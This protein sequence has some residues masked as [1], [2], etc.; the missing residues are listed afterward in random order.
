MYMIIVVACRAIECKTARSVSFQIVH[1]ASQS[2]LARHIP[3]H[4]LVAK[5]WLVES[6]NF[7]RAALGSNHSFCSWNFRLAEL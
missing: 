5:P 3:H 7:C 6:R 2:P 4:L 1:E